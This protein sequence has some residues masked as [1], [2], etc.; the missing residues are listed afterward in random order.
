[1]EERIPAGLFTRTAPQ[2]FS[3]GTPDWGKIKETALERDG[4]KRREAVCVPASHMKTAIFIL[5]EIWIWK[6]LLEKRWW[7]HPEII[8]FAGG[9][10]KRL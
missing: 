5:E 7:L 3:Y 8:L 4:G 6:I 1:M 2:V 9:K 10:W